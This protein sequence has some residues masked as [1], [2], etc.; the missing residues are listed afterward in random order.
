[1]P[2]FSSTL[3]PLLLPALTF[4]VP[5]IIRTQSAETIPN[6]WIARLVPDAGLPD[7]LSSVFSTAGVESKLN[8]TI[9]SVTGFAFD[10][11]DAVLDALQSLGEI[12]HVEPDVVMRASVPI[13]LF[14]PPV[15]KPS[16]V[17]GTNTTAPSNSSSDLVTQENS[18]WGLARISHKD[19]GASD[20]VYD[21]SAGEGTFVY[22]IDT[23]INSA[24]EEF[25]GGRAVLGQSFVD[26][27]NGEDDQ[28]HGT[29]C[30]G[31][32]GG[33]TYGVA[34][35]TTMI[36]IK[37]LDASGSGST[38]T[39]L[40]GLSWALSD[41]ATHGRTSRSIISMS[42]GGP[43]SLITNNAIT[44]AVAS[45]AFIV[46]AAGNENADVSTTS[47]ASAPDAC[48]V[49]ASTDGDEKAS[50]SNFG[51]GVDVFAPGKD[52]ES[53]WIGGTTR[54]RTISGTSMAAPHVAG[55]AAH[56]IAKEGEMAPTALCARIK[57]L[58]VQGVISGV[59]EETA[60]V[61]VQNGSGL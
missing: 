33:T 42:L 23:G 34:K 24:H 21:A 1:M 41:M 46:V 12:E 15:Y 50:F 54:T 60:N 30:A 22:I 28:G 19:A 32:V 47:P 8:Y 7:A 16:V 45:G 5:T 44:S 57:E 25:A 39:V 48:T 31:T 56:L 29:H 13:G 20:Y 35:N 36:A 58:G 6:S 3:L 49:A 17:N 38:S 37:V 4:A 27:S 40:K 51:T 61:L 14:D 26:D 9:G 59:D 18:T 43:Y 52:V 55:L 2:T 11:D 53:A 10:G